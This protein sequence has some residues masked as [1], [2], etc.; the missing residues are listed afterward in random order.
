[1]RLTLLLFALACAIRT[2]AAAQTTQPLG[3]RGHVQSLHLYGT[4]GG[5]PV[6]VS[7]G[8]GGWIHL[9]PHVAE[10]LAAKGCF[11]VGFDVKAYLE[12]FTSGLYHPEARGRARRL[13]GA[14][15]F[16]GGGS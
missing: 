12:S 5:Q 11:V 14:G 13:Q 2:P 8:D 10:A 6:I 9:G 1:M 4:R 3:L 16:C 15:G 7:S